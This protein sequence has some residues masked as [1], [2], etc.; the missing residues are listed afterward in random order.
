MLEQPPTPANRNNLA[1]FL[2]G[3]L[4][5]LAATIVG[6]WQILRPFVTQDHIGMLY[7]A[8]V[9][10]WIIPMAVWVWCK[11]DVTRREA[12][13]AEA[14]AAERVAELAAQIDRLGDAIV[15]NQTEIIALTSNI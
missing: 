14:A 2:A 5:P 10:C 13:A 3:S 7:I 11:V 9:A 8:M 1:H 15:D 4:P 6:L 12:E